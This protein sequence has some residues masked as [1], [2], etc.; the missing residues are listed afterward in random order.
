VRSDAER[1]RAY[2]LWGYN[3]ASLVDISAA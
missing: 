3:D 1:T 2:T